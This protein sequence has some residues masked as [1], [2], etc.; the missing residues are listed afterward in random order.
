MI[1]CLKEVANKPTR[2]FVDLDAPRHECWICYDR[3]RPDV[4]PMIFPCQCKGDLVAVHHDC[5]KRWLI[6]V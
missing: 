5:L 2:L 6:E 3:D 4:G 1:L